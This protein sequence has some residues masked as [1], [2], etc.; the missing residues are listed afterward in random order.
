MADTHDPPHT[1]HTLQDGERRLTRVEAELKSVGREVGELKRGQ[2][3]LE[4]SLNTGFE[5]LTDASAKRGQTNWPVLL[6]LASLL[7][8]ALL[9]VLNMRVVPLERA[10]VVHERE[11]ARV[12]AE[13]DQARRE[14]AN[15]NE[16]QARADERMAVYREQGFF[17]RP[18][19]N[20]HRREKRR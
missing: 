20:P 4:R 15:L 6:G 8:G 2:D 14:A 17:D 13:I 7:G 9:G 10:D 16:R 5:R 18:P 12:G 3:S 19:T 1:G 11:M